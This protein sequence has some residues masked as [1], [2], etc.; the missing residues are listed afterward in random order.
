ML[1]LKRWTHDTYIVLIGHVT[2][3][4]LLSI[5]SN[6]DGVARLDRATGIPGLMHVGVHPFLR[7]GPIYLC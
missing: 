3:L 1:T 7:V 4:V 6:R 2:R 5:I